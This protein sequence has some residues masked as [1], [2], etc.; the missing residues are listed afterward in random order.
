M[1]RVIC[2]FTRLLSLRT[3]WRSFGVIFVP[4]RQVAFF[5]STFFSPST[6]SVFLERASTHSSALVHNPPIAIALARLGIAFDI[7]AQLKH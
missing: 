4:P 1:R 6:F 5:A 2:T 7:D 3:F